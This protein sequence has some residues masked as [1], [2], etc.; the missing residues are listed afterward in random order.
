MI[1]DDNVVLDAKGDGNRGID[2]GDGVF[3][4]RNTILYCKDGDIVVGDRVSFSANCQVASAR[5]VEIGADTVDRLL[6]LPPQRRGVRPRE[7]H[8]LRAPERPATRR[9]SCA[10]AATAGS[11]RT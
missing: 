5:R 11:G 4:G 10:S 2:L 9:A 7:R 3:V 6:Q 1:V 8:A